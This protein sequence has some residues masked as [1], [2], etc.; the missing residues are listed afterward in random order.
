[1]K[2]KI[3]HL[4]KLI[5]NTLLKE[6][7]H[8]FWF[9][10]KVRFITNIP[11]AGS[12]HPGRPKE[13]EGEVYRTLALDFTDNKTFLQ[14]RGVQIKDFDVKSIKKTPISRGTK[15]YYDYEIILEGYIFPDVFDGFK[16][17]RSYMDNYNFSYSDAVK[18]FIETFPLH[19][20]FTN[21]LDNDPRKI[22]I[23]ITSMMRI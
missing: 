12:V 16:V 9:I 18:R 7:K 1:M 8:Q 13:T 19:S 23:K 17:F 14:K 22:S 15:N 5:E 20:F 21:K 10:A 11:I 4:K 2:I 3:K 6:Q